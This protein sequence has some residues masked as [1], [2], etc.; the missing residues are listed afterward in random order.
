MT[1]FGRDSMVASFEALPFQP[2]LAE[3]TL[4]VLA[5]LQAADWDNFADAE[6]GKLPHEVRRG[7]LSALGEHPGV[8]Y[9]AH[10]GPPLFLIL[11]D[12]YGRWTGDHDLVRRLE[13]AARAALAWIEGPGDP[14]G[15]GYLEYRS[16]SRSRFALSNHCWRDSDDAIV[17]ADGRRAEPPLATSDIQGYAYDAR[18][19]LARLAREVYDDPELAERLER[20]AAA[21][22]ERFNRDYWSSNR[23]HYVLALDRDKRQVDSL[24]SNLGHLLWSGIVDERRVA[25]TARLLL[26]DVLFTGYGIR[27]MSAD[28]VGYDPL[29]YH[30]GTVWPHDTAIAAAGLRRQGLVDEAARICLALLDA[31]VAFDYSLPELFGGFQRDAAGVPVPYPNALKPQAWAAAAPLL[32]VRTLLGLEVVD[33]R[34]VARPHVPERIRPLRLRGLQARG[35][36]RDA[37]G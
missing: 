11:L 10:D 6:P 23:G 12:E 21:L 3:A 22:H 17:F 26:S 25:S 29:A 20:D 16:R 32:A 14:D 7:I 31:A 15:D 37:S 2:H 36:E 4:E 30:R 28:D 18:L 24:T 1:V 9:G 19:R 27:S 34:V 8:Y 5:G 33:G 13:P 35:S